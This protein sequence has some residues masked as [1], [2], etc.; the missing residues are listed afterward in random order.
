LISSELFKYTH[1]THYLTL[2]TFFCMQIVGGAG[3]SEP[4]MSHNVSV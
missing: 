1:Y 3:F 2:S 4:A